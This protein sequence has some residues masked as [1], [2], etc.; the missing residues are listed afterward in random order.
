VGMNSSQPPNSV[1]APEASEQMR[2]RLIA[3]IARLATGDD[4]ALWAHRSLGEKSKLIAADADRVERAFT[5][6]LQKLGTGVGDA[7]QAK[8]E[9]LNPPV[10]KPQTAR[11]GSQSNG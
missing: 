8:A 7:P 9:A 3:E 5:A 6:K 4:A 11:K 10:A 2:D 1:L